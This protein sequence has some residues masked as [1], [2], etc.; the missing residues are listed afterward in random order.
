M[1][2]MTSVRRALMELTMFG[3]YGVSD[4]VGVCEFIENLDDSQLNDLAKN[5]IMSENQNSCKEYL[6]TKYYEDLNYKNSSASIISESSFSNRRDQILLNEA[7]NKGD[8]DSLV[9]LLK[10]SGWLAVA[11]YIIKNYSENPAEIARQMTILRQADLAAYEQ[12]VSHIRLVTRG[13]INLPSRKHTDAALTN[14]HNA[15]QKMSNQ[16]KERKPINND[17]K[18]AVNRAK[19][20]VLRAKKLDLQKGIKDSSQ[21]KKYSGKVILSIMGLTGLAILLSQIYHRYLSD[22]AKHCRG[23]SGK[24]RTICINTFKINACDAAIHKARE[25]LTGCK[26]RVNP[27]KCV[28]SIQTQIWNWEKKKREYQK[29]MILAK[30]EIVSA[31]HPPVTPVENHRS[32]DGGGVF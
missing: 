24:D 12:I 11:G 4:R 15:Q 9:R 3:E 10:T 23:K 17:L 22:A 1:N 19:D 16:Y 30:R 25:A 14:L 31:T 13:K 29:H 28:H 27:E 6:E 2:S 26:D 18:N 7:D 5:I 32:T 8:S 21:A 20:D